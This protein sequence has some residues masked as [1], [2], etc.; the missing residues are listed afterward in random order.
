MLLLD[1]AKPGHCIHRCVF[2]YAFEYPESWN[3][4]TPLLVYG[5]IVKRLKNELKK[6]KICPPF[7]IS[8][9]SDPFQPVKEVLIRSLEVT[10]LLLKHGL[11]FHH[12]TKSPLVRRCLDI[13]G[14][15]KYPYYHLQ[16]SLETVNPDKARTLSNAPPPR[17][18]M[19]ILEEFSKEGVYTI[20]RLDPIIYGFTSDLDEINELIEW[21]SSIGVKHV[22]SSTGRF[23]QRT[24]LKIVERLKENGYEEEA[25]TVSSTYVREVS[26]YYRIPLKLRIK[27]HRTLKEMVEK[28]GMYY[29]VCQ[30]L[31]WSR[32]LDSANLPNCE[33]ERNWI[34]IRVDNE[35][36][37]LCNK[38]CTLCTNPA[39]N[40]PQLLDQ[41][42][43][44][45]RLRM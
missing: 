24:L 3:G 32:G 22:I 42:L 29:S 5:N 27:F 33:G 10:E 18:R 41:P 45:S 1:I 44:L 14:L 7:Y 36:R 28:R 38:S 8:P 26:D 23:K 30:E 31:N 6:L 43:K 37:P 35:W 9:A 25:K 13:D 11:S 39:C 34:M 16:V 15:T 40:L 21:A 20:L 2:C 19:D 17:E 4:S 12:V